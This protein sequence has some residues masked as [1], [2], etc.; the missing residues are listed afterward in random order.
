MA[1]DTLNALLSKNVELIDVSSL[2]GLIIN[3]AQ[4]CCSVDAGRVFF[5]VFFC[6]ADACCVL[7][8]TIG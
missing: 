8:L 3:V 5:V 6:F 2:R 4:T 7:V 1:Y